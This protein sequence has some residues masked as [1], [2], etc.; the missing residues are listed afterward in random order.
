MSVKT[1]IVQSF[2]LELGEGLTIEGEVK[3]RQD[4][5]LKPVVIVNHGFR[6]HKD[7]AFWPEVTRQL[8]EEGFYTVSYNFSRIAAV[9]DGLTEQ[10][11]AEAT[12][13]SQEQLDLHAVT[14]ALLNRELPLAEQ[15]DTNRIGLVGHSRAG[16]SV[17]VYAAEH[18]EEVQ[19]IVVWNGGA[20][21]VRQQEQAG[22]PAAEQA[23]KLSVLEATLHEDQ[24]RNAERYALVERV[25][26]LAAQALIVQGG[27]DREQLLEQFRAFQERAPQHHYLAIEGGN[28]TFNTVHP[29]EGG[30][31]QLSEAVEATLQ[32]L[33]VQLG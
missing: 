13:L 31:P 3:S 16:G 1:L 33:R 6:G 22:K 4:N 11:I 21:P 7:W 15:A 27:D 9:R 5:V 17:I 12:T 8:A 30:S 14:Q 29:Y 20:G 26:A 19:A 28:H 25:E 24:L 2:K 18:P 32:F 23:E 10:Q